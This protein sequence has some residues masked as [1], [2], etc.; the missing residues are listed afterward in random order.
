[1]LRQVVLSTALLHLQS[2]RWP[3][4]HTPPLGSD[5]PDDVEKCHN[6][7]TLTQNS[8]LQSHLRRAYR[9]QAASSIYHARVHARS[10]TTSSH[11]LPPPL[12]PASASPRSTRGGARRGGLSIIS[13]QRFA[14]DASV[15]Q[16]TGRYWDLMIGQGITPVHVCL[17]NAYSCPTIVLSACLSQCCLY[18]PT[19]ATL[20]V[21]D[22]RLQLK[23]QIF[24]TS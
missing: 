14:S 9:P 19:S 8:E 3:I 2:R 11:R 23:K 4:V 18:S 13:S 7:R 5:K 15:S 10:R 16:V 6:S 1:M 24:E 12:P 20:S 22:V 17:G 21:R